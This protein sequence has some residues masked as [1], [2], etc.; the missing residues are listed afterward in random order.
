ML[1]NKKH[2]LVKYRPNN[3]IC[4]I[5]IKSNFIE[6]CLHLPDSKGLQG[7]CTAAWAGACTASRCLHFSLASTAALQLVS[8]KED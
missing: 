4:L 5:T 2:F 7:S 3:L 1:Y 8:L 6:I